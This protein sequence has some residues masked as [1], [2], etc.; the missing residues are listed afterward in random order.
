MRKESWQPV[1][2]NK[3]EVQHLLAYDYGNRFIE[4]LL[5]FE[6]RNLPNQTLLPFFCIHCLIHPFWNCGFKEGKRDVC[7]NQGSRT[8]CDVGID[9]KTPDW[10]SLRAHITFIVLFKNINVECFNSSTSWDYDYNWLG[11]YNAMTLSRTCFAFM[12]RIISIMRNPSNKQ[13]NARTTK[14]TAFPQNS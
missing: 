9:Q 11:Y 1:Y 10:G 7:N 12:G 14:G 4:I 13:T 8:T 3:V 6:E 2:V 5:M